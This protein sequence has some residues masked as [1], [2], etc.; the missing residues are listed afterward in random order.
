[1][2]TQRKTPWQRMRERCTEF[3][4]ATCF[5]RRSIMWRYE[6][7]ALD[8]GW[9]LS[10]L[11]E[12]VAAAQQLGFEVYLTAD[13]DGLSVRYQEKRPGWPTCL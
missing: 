10:H 7:N 2:T 3:A 4:N 8:K 13:E 5:P 11:Y 6:R 1:M 12:R 9:A